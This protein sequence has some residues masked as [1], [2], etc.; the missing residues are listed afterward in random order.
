LLLTLAIVSVLIGLLAP[1]LGMVRE[2]AHRLACASHQHSLGA[3]MALFARDNRDRTPR[4]YF[5]RSDV[6]LPQEMMAA[7]IGT[8]APVPDN[9]EG[10]GWL[11]V[12]AGG[13][14]DNNSCFY[15][16]SHRGNHPS[17]RY[18]SKFRL[19][20]QRVYINYHYSG[21][22]SMATG[23][24]RL[25]DQPVSHIFLTDGLRTVS[26]FNHGNGANR[27]HGD[28]SVSWKHDV[29]EVMASMLPTVAMPA[30]TQPDL[31]QSIWE[32]ILL[33]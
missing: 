31:Y 32:A 1:A 29:N 3:A 8:M 11:S 6:R 20:Q 27:L 12:G 13:Y 5:G 30:S 10:L 24:P 33:E 28:L 18:L 7:T 25:I 26:D 2:T 16:S 17:E 19:G 9:W 15:C 14:V 4:S 21:D 22:V 23:R